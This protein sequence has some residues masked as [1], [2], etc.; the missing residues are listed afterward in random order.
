MPG[1]AMIGRLDQFNSGKAML[2]HI[3]SSYV[4]LGQVNP[5]YE[6]LLH[7]V[8]GYIMSVLVKSGKVR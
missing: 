1:N 2:D 7:V 3:I 8:S 4:R 5:D 6:F